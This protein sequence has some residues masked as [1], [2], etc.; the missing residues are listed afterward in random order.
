MIHIPGALAVPD[1][2]TLGIALVVVIL[3]VAAVIV[4]LSAVGSH[5]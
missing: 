2:T 5:R 4:A 1:L 3:I